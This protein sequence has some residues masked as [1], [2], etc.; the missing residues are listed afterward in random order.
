MS[1]FGECKIGPNC[2][3]GLLKSFNLDIEVVDLSV[4]FAKP[5]GPCNANGMR[6][7]RYKLLV[8]TSKQS[9]IAHHIIV[10]HP[11]LLAKSDTSF[12]HIHKN[13]PGSWIHH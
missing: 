4:P 12:E 3:K 6:T 2:L 1:A 10:V 7:P 9:P 8:E 5:V 11:V 13:D